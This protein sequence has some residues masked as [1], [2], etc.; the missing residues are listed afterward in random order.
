LRDARYE[1]HRRFRA[2]A[3]ELLGGAGRVA[4]RKM[5]GGCGLCCDGMM[6]GLIA[7]T[8]CDVKSHDV[9]RPG[10]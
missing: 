7:T 2:Y 10:L 8:C 3:I 4:A 5:F 1:S 9:N 6:C